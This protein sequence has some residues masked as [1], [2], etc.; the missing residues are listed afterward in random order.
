MQQKSNYVNSE[1]GEDMVIDKLIVMDDVSGFAD[2]SDEFANFL[3]VSS[4]Y[5]LTCSYIFHTIYPCRQNWEMIMS[6]TQI[7]I[8]FPGSVRSSTI[9]RTLSLFANRYKNTYLPIRNVCLNKLYFDKSNSRQKQCLAVD[10][11]DV[12]DL[13]PGKFRTQADKGT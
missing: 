9:N 10:T 2:K 13:G 3:T 4:K 7:F 5:G 6:Q 12:N 1:L 8:S 11:R